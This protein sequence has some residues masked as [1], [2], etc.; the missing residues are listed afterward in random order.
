MIFWIHGKRRIYDDKHKLKPNRALLQKDL[1]RSLYE[2]ETKIIFNRIQN[3]F[4]F[5][6]LAIKQSLET[7]LNFVRVT[8]ILRHHFLKQKIDHFLVS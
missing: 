7:M 8:H 3:P 5:I 6:K 2:T 4:Q 1:E